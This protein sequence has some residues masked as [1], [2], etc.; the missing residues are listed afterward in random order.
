MG[1][2]LRSREPDPYTSLYE[3]HAREGGD[4]GDGDYELIGRLE[5]HVLEA[6]G[7]TPSS[8]VLDLGCG[9][10]RLA[11]HVVPY[12]SADGHYIG[13]DV[14][15]TF[16]AR[17]AQRIAALVPRPSTRVTLRQQSTPDFDLPAASIDMACAFSVFTHLEHED[18]H[19]YLVGLRRVVRSSGLLVIS[20]LPLDLAVAREV[21]VAQAALDIRDRWRRP[22]NI[23]TT[24]EAVET[25]ARLAGW[26]TVRWL[27]GDEPHVP[28]PDGASARFGQTLVVLRPA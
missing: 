13:I 20:V 4:V 11:V 16:L 3:R 10:G 2:R 28:M 25:I 17:A 19:R 27:P 18:M 5:L 23:T 12:L 14:S 7:L 22:R 6:F 9:D 26:E 8:T 21:F 24:R 1:E 15:K